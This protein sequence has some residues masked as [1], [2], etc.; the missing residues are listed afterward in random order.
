MPINEAHPASNGFDSSMLSHL[1]IILA[2]GFT[3]GNLVRMLV[4]LFSTTQLTILS[5]TL[6]LH[7]SQ[8]HRSVDFHPIL[9]HG[10][11]FWI[12]LTTSMVTKEWVAIH[13]KHHAFSDTAQD[14]H[15]PHVFGIRKLLLEGTELYID[16]RTDTNLLVKYGRGTPD[17]WIER[18]LYTPHCNWGPT[19][20]AFINI[21]LFGV[22]GMAVWAT[23]MMWIPFWA[24][25]VVNGL[26][27]WR[28]YRSYETADRSV[29]LIPLGFWVGG[30]ELH[31]NHHAFPSSVKFSM[32]P[33]EFDLGWMVIQLL[34]R[35]R[36][37]DVRRVACKHPAHFAKPVQLTPRVRIMTEFVHTVVLPALRDEA[38]HGG[39]HGRTLSRRLRHSFADGGY[40]LTND[41]RERID[42]W[43]HAHPNL[44]TILAYR[45]KLAALLEQG[46]SEALI[47]V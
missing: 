28:G 18:K 40:G 33:Y 12:W 32:R 42:A 16:A 39:D 7:R 3:H 19:L 6:Y 17:D 47:A 44:S 4:Y 1:L 43:M 24:A 27:H 30:E 38:K 41:D 2:H 13:R 45:S 31:N 14:P 10:F 22:L 35:L 20:L 21:A 37:A 8:T 23:Q 29:N 5:V 15:S 26:G 11:R 46:W 9:A 34:Q 36:L 25:G